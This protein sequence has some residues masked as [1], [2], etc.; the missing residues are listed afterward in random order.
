MLIDITENQKQIKESLDSGFFGI[1]SGSAK[2]KTGF[3]VGG[4]VIGF[5]YAISRQKQGI[6]GYV[7]MGLIVGA[8][9]GWTADYLMKNFNEQEKDNSSTVK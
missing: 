1:M 7:L 9:T 8:M 3:A 4:A 6:M 5:V 2:F